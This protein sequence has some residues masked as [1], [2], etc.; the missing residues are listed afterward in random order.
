VVGEE[1]KIKAVLGRKARSSGVGKAGIFVLRR[2]LGK[3]EL[4]RIGGKGRV[5]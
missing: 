3:L 1:F 4:R 5:F 2:E